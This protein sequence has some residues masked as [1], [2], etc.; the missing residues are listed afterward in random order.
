ME[1]I[2]EITQLH[3][4][5]FTFLGIISAI[6]IGIIAYKKYQNFRN[7]EAGRRNEI[8]RYLKKFEFSFKKIIER[9][10]STEEFSRNNEF[11]KMILE[12]LAVRSIAT[13]QLGHFVYV[14]DLLLK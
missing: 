9:I 6:T 4:V 14:R 1:V 2:T 13:H 11:N 12:I 8:E 7:F 10:D 5:I 3:N